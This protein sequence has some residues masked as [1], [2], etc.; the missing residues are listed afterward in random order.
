MDLIHVGIGNQIA[1]LDSFDGTEV[2]R[3]KLPRHGHGSF[4]SLTLRD[5]RLYAGLFGVVYC[6]DALTG[7]LLWTNSMKG[8]GY[9]L[10]SFADVPAGSLASAQIGTDAAA[11]TTAAAS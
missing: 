3:T 6:L 10:V 2:W 9:G 7:T 11:A 5:G 1:A 4:V 8:T